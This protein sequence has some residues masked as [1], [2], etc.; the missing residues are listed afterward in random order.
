MNVGELIERLSQYPKDRHVFL[1][2]D[3]IPK[4]FDDALWELRDVGIRDDNLYWV[5]TEDPE[6]SKNTFDTVLE[7]VLIIDTTE[8]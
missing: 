3:D 5:V 4:S 1:H 7:D 6:W 2:V 8:L